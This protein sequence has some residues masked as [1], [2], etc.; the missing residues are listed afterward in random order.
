MSVNKSKLNKDALNVSSDSILRPKWAA[1]QVCICKEGINKLT[2]TYASNRDIGHWHW[3]STEYSIIT[4]IN[5]SCN[6]KS[7]T[8]IFH[9]SDK[10]RLGSKINFPCSVPLQT[11]LLTS[12]TIFNICQRIS[13]GSTELK[14]GVHGGM[15]HGILISDLKLCLAKELKNH[16]KSDL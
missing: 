1:I 5:L 4:N 15:S 2:K 13:M 8:R 7:F 14:T 3:F 16:R 10:Q 6:L 11:P 9:L 12:N